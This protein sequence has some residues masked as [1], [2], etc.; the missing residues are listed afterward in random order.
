MT[1]VRI[2]WPF[3]VDWGNGYSIT[4]AYQ[5]DVFT[6]RAGGEQ[7]RAVRETP[8]KRIEFRAR[9]LNETQLRLFNR[10]LDTAQ[11]LAVV[12]PEATRKIRTTTA[13]AAGATTLTVEAVPLWLAAGAEIVLVSGVERKIASVA[14]VA[15]S[16]VTFTAAVGAWPQGTRIHPSL[17]G[18]V[19]PDI[20]APRS[21]NAAASATIAFEAD[22]GRETYAPGTA[23]T[24]LDGIEVLPLRPNWASGIEARHIWPVEEVD[25]G[26]GRISLHRP[27]DFPTRLRSAAYLGRSAADVRSIEDCFHRAKGRRGAFWAESGENDLPPAAA[28]SAAGTTLT[29]A[30]VETADAYGVSP[31]HQAVAVRLSNGQTLHRRVTSVA[32]SA[33]NSVVTVSAAW[34][35]AAQP[36]EI[37][38][39]SWLLLS[40][41][42][43]DELT[44]EW[45]SDEVAQARLAIRSLPATAPTDYLLLRAT[46]EGDQRETVPGDERAVV[47]LT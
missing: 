37:V 17:T 25:F 16:V 14:S 6:A 33:G 42:A 23:A 13:S 12:L 44:V 30:G 5:T 9:L 34:G 36:S 24:L 21:S 10:I 39:V 2:M 20:S 8:R 22:P 26:A 29:I 45:L 15:G 32:A 27:V 7:R 1:D 3:D 40:R 46:L 31:V 18:Q 38:R 43:S 28:L 41:F 4:Y 47:Y 19:D 11:N 35:V